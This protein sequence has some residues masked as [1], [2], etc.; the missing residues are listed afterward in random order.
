MDSAT[1]RI[2]KGRGFM[3]SARYQIL[4]SNGFLFIAPYRIL[5]GNGFPWYKHCD[6]L[7]KY[8]SW[9]ISGTNMIYFDSTI[10]LIFLETM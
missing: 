3:D 1:Y 7:L 8:F 2:L 10:L 5:E 6:M 9:D 4:N